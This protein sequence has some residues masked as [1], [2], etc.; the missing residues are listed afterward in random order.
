MFVYNY[1]NVPM[2]MVKFSGW[3]FYTLPKVN[4]VFEDRRCPNKKVKNE[5][6]GEEKSPV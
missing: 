4:F 5:A 2:F 3:V 1:N 6:H